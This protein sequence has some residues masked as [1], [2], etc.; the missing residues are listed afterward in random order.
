V[1]CELVCEVD[2]D[3]GRQSHCNIFCTCIAFQDVIA[4]VP[5]HWSDGAIEDKGSRWSGQVQPLFALRVLLLLL[6]WRA[7]HGIALCCCQTV[8][9]TCILS[10]TVWSGY[11]DNPR[12][13]CFR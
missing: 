12:S 2:V 9:V 4:N 13:S 1:V 8:V 11:D 6:Q 10:F 3:H 5:P 7:A